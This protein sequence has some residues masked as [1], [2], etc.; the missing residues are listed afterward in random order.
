MMNKDNI[1][2]K[3]VDYELRYSRNEKIR[4]FD[5][6]FDTGGVSKY[7]WNTIDEVY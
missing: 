4:A 2:Y 6:L 3:D 7:K 5:K 1:E